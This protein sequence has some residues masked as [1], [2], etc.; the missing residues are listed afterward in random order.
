[1]AADAASCRGLTGSL[2]LRDG[3]R[4]RIRPSGPADRERLAACFGALSPESRRLRFFGHKERLQPAELDLYTEVDGSDHIALAAI[5]LDALGEEGEAL[6]FARCLRIP[7]MPETAELSLTVLDEAQGQGVGRALL[8]RLIE[9]ARD[10]GIRNLHCDI[11]ADNTSMRRLAAQLGGDARWMG[12]GTLACD[13]PLPA[14][15]DTAQE[16]GLP[17]FADPNQWISTGS[18]AFLTG[19]E[20]ALAGFQAGHEA[21]DQWLSETCP[22]TRRRSRLYADLAPS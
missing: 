19:L 22:R 10:R 8:S 21:W 12:D 15:P 11:L 13:C 4:Y 2:R 3:T 1:M 17:W 6:G 14:P 9:D 7:E 16:G 20:T 18:D 5:R